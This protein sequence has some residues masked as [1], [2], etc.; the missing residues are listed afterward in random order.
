MTETPAAQTV[1]AADL[2]GE[3]PPVT[4]AVVNAAPPPAG[5]VTAQDPAPAPKSPPPSA[6]APSPWAHERDSL[7]R[8]FDAEKFATNADG[9]PRRDKVGRFIPRGLGRK[10]AK[11]AGENESFVAPEAPPPPPPKA[12]DQFDAAGAAATAA[13]IAVGVTAFGDEWVPRPGE[14]ENLQAAFAAYFRAKGVADVPPGLALCIA[15]LGYAG[16]R[17]TQPKTLTRLQKFKLWLA[18]LRAKHAAHGLAARMPNVPP[19]GG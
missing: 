10:A 13:T 11:P 14:G 19:A 17:F 15:L 7:D 12:M 5:D 3:L 2:V 1:S 16:P 18:S 9:S 8:A 6:A 4:P